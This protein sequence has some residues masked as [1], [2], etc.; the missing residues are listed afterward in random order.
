MKKLLLF[1][2]LIP[3]MLIWN[4]CSKE[5]G[6]GGN[7]SIHGKVYAKYYD[8]YFQV[9]QGQGYAGDVDV[10]IIYGDDL[11]YS[12]KTK[13]SYDGTKENTLFMLTQKIPLSLFLLAPMRL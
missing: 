4:S 5:P 11:S 7:A 6:V 8:K 9:L 2:F 12:D 3:I 13:T 10:Y 1:S